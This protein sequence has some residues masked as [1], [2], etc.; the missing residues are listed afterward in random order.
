MKEYKKGDAVY[1][2]TGYGKPYSDY[3][4]YDMFI[5]DYGN[6]QYILRADV[7]GIGE[8]IYQIRDWGTISESENGPLNFLTQTV[9]YKSDKPY[10]K[11]MNRTYSR[12]IL[13]G[14]PKS[15]YDK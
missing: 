5:D 13:D 4:V 12:N 11:C 6:T 10:T 15:L 1:I 8:W 2:S 3:I 14:G 9:F 7:P